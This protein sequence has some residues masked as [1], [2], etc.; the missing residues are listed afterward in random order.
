VWL[1]VALAPLVA[2]QLSVIAMTGPHARYMLPAWIGAVASLPVLL[3]AAVRV[4]PQA[5]QAAERSAGTSAERT[6]TT[7][8]S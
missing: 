5:P 8:E 6:R 7:T 1:V 2:Q 3:V 4:R